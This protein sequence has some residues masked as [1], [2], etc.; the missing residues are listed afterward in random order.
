MN[1]L[2]GMTANVIVVKN[3][4]TSEFYFST[5]KPLWESVGVKLERFDAITPKT[6]PDGPLKFT[7]VR[8]RKYQD[9]TNRKGKTFTD[10]EKAVWYSHYM[11]WKKC[12]ESNEPIVVIEHDCVP[13]DEAKLWY[14]DGT[15]FKSFDMGALGCYV[16]MPD[17]AK[18]VLSYIDLPT[19]NIESG[20]LGCLCSFIYHYEPKQG[21]ADKWQFIEKLDSKRYDPGCTQIISRTF[22]VTVDHYTGTEVE[23]NKKIAAPWPFYVIIDD[24]PEPLSV[25][26]VKQHRRSF[27]NPRTN[28]HGLSTTL[29]FV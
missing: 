23:D 26:A 5:I 28:H 17:F 9:I 18:A 27:D 11:L 21:N 16:M 25:E 8:T 6:L 7:A 1:Y 22:G 20:P 3:N 12:A 2:R 14:D 24:L 19:T 4:T 29:H 15:H 13:F 10:T